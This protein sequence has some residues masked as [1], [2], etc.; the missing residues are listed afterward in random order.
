LVLDL[1]HVLEYLWKAVHCFHPV[2]SNEAEEWVKA[3]ALQVLQGAA[4]G[5]AVDLRREATRKQLSQKR[6]RS[7]DKCANYLD[8][9]SPML[10]YDSYLSDG[11]PIASSGDLDAYWGFHREQELQ[12]NHI[13]RYAA[14]S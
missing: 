3:K 14:V 10:E 11:L 4:E 7:V 9:Y 6:R 8:K 2:A 1:I 12:R 13:S 5:V